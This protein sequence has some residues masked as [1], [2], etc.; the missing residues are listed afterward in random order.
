[1]SEPI[2]YAAVWRAVMQAAGYRCQCIGQCG[3]PHKNSSGRCPREHGQCASKHRGP[4]HLT[5]APTDLLMSVRDAA[6]LP[7]AA[8]RALCPDCRD[9]ARRAAQRATR[10]Q[11]DTAQGCLFD[12]AA[13]PRPN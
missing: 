11:P 2:A 10:A 9:D 3:N 8:L 13:H 12:I 6:Q 1:M 5:A 7:A 4:V